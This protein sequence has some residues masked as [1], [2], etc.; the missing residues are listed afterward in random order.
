MEGDSFSETSGGKLLTHSIRK[1]PA[2]YIRRNG[3]SYDDVDARG[4]LKSNFCMVDTYIDNSIPYPDVKKAA[5]LCIGGAVNYV[6]RE[7]SCVLSN[8]SLTYICANI[9]II[10]PRG[11][12]LILGTTLL[13]GFY[14]DLTCQL[15]PYSY[16]EGIQAKVALLQSTLE[17]NEN[18]VKEMQVI[19]GGHGGV[20]VITDSED[21]N[22]GGANIS[23]LSV[24]DNGSCAEV[25]SA[26]ILQFLKQ[27][28]TSLQTQLHTMRASLTDMIGKLHKAVLQMV[29]SSLMYSRE[30]EGHGTINTLTR[31]TVNER[32]PLSPSP[33]SQHTVNTL[34][35]EYQYGIDGRKPAKLFIPEERGKVKHK[36][37]I[38]KPFWELISRMAQ[39]EFTSQLAIDKLH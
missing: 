3:C 2:T 7:G 37:C 30:R 17:S 29:S 28:N 12:A 15:F 36:Y 18:P 33:K 20:L 24:E 13:W 10:F 5:V 25:K 27:Q 23:H 34:W 32:A 21:I 16:V 9:A 14:D 22:M 19:V 35:L 38:R 39:N 4:K 6:V 11:A 31:S 1:L 26:T 8:F